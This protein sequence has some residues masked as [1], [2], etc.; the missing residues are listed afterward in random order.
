MCSGL[1]SPH[2]ARVSTLVIVS[3]VVLL[4]LLSIAAYVMFLPSERQVSTQTSP[5]LTTPTPTSPTPT[6]TPT[7]PTPTP[8]TT[9]Q[10]TTPA[11]T[12]P[13]PTP[14]VGPSIELVV[15]TRHST[16]IQIAARQKF[17]QSELAKKYGITNLRFLYIDAPAWID[18]IKQYLEAG[19]SIDVAW[20]GG[21]TL[22]DMLL[23]SGLLSPIKSPVV[24]SVLSDI[25]KEIAGASMV[26]DVNGSI[27]WIA[28]AISS[29]GFTVNEVKVSQLGIPY[30][31]SWADL[32]RPE[33]AIRMP[34]PVAGLADAIYS[35]SNTRMF[36]II[37]QTYGWVSG[38]KLL[39]LIG[40]NSV[41]YTGS[42]DVREG[43]IRG[44]IAVGLTIDFYGYGAQLE[45][46]NTKYVLPADGTAINGDPIALLV[47]SRNSEAAQAFIAWVL[48]PEGQTIWMDEKINRMPINPKVFDVTEEGRKRP[49][50]KRAY[51]DTLRALAIEFSDELALSYEQALMWFF[52]ATI[53]DPTVNSKLKEV[54]KELSL[55]YLT[56]RISK[57]KF[58]EL[59]DDLGNPEKLAFRIPGSGA[60]ATFT[61]KLAQELNDKVATDRDFRDAIV[62]EWKERAI[63]RYDSVL[64]KLWSL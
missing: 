59:I 26:R 41:V 45:N 17:L 39:T 20:G 36:E 58:E 2:V 3:V 37:V 18:T 50:L 63:E 28:A 15:I 32:A 64:R 55:A 8:Q 9:P 5:T 33:Y 38:W 30:P 60:T 51:E 40:A 35:T 21:P 11:T 10:I 62:R 22:F 53:G 23:S 7:T 44:D 14:T 52:H 4:V 31:R 57:E 13:T 49:D 25:P 54:W 42:G 27:Y 47:S 48:S 43:V 1:R 61:E 19:R 16:D 29:F 12:T 34:P 24:L 6:P 46:P 56:G